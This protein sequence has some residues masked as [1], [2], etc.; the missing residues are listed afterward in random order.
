MVAGVWW[1]GVRYGCRS[2]VARG[3]EMVAGVWWQ[4]VRDGCRSVVARGERW[5]QECGGKG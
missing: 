1:Q 4:G 2:V 3:R 5:L